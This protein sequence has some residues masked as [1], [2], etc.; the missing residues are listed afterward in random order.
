M[1]YCGIDKI[2]QIE[3]V[4][5][6]ATKKP[7]DP[8]LAVAMAVHKKGMQPDYSISLYPGTGTVDGK[9]GDHIL[10]APAYNV[11]ERDIEVIVDLTAKVIEDV[12]SEMEL[13]T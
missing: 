6:R 9:V 12:F 2:L 5:D 13:G 1:K 10:I 4:Q 3:F 7:F 11:T 8:K